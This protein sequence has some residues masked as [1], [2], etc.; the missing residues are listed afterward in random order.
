MTA[1]QPRAM[2]RD[3]VRRDGRLKV[4]GTAPFA[5]EGPPGKAAYCPLIQ[6]T[7]A[8]GRVTTMDI[9]SVQAVEGVITVLTAG[10][11]ERL[12]STEDNELA[13]LQSDEIAF[14]GQ[15]IGAVIAETSEVA[16]HA[17][18]LVRVT[19]A[20]QPHDVELSADR[21]D[22]YKPDKL[23]ASYPTDTA[24]GDVAAAMARAPITFEQIYTTAIYHNNPMEP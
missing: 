4:T 2:G 5:Y 12:A 23:N 1:L 15:I 17:A 6:A 22:L 11:V 21:A 7:I 20:Q 8:R 24:E 18:A 10:S 16:R 3:L 9:T 14:R 19:Y 13:V